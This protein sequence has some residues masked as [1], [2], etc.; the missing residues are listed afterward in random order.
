MSYSAETVKELERKTKVIRRRIVE[1]L[2][3]A[4]A[5][6]PGPSLSIVEILTSLYF[7]TMRVDPANPKWPDRDRFILSKGHAAIAYYS[8]LAERGF[9]PV[10]ELKTFDVIN[11]R[12]QGH[13]DCNKTPGVEISTGS[14]GQGLSVGCGMAIAAKMME[15]DYRTYVLIGDGEAQEGQIWE[16]ALTAVK[17][18]LDN[19]TVYV[20]HNKLQGGIMKEVMPNFPPIA[21][22]F[23]GFGWNTYE[24]DGHDLN[25][26]LAATELAKAYKDKPS[27]II[28]H[29]VKGKGCSFMEGDVNWHSQVL[30][31]TNAERALEETKEGSCVG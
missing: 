16:A 28:C 25:Q 29:T 17:Y 22:K 11:S 27:I 31:G 26:I 30:E 3:H 18:K 21:P 12:L 24:I 4:K 20:D 2:I 14:L 10:D 23:A 5:G 8:V 9:L 15:K 19:L 1:T 7:H 6:H 13:P